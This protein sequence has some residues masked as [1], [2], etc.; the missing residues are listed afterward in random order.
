MRIDPSKYTADQY[1]EAMRKRHAKRLASIATH[2][3]E[4]VRS[5]VLRWFQRWSQANPDAEYEHMTR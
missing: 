1:I 5:L 4:S 3:P 2:D